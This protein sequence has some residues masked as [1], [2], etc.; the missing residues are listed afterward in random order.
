LQDDLLVAGLDL[1]TGREVHVSDADR[2]YWHARGYSGR[3]T[4]VCA[5]CYTGIDDAPGTR[6]PLVVRGRIGGL[7]RLHFAH[8]PGQAPVGGHHPESVWHLSAKA[9][10]AAWAC[11]QPGVVDVAVERCTPDRARRSDVRVRFYDGRQVALEVQAAPLT[12]Q[13]WSARHADY[14]RQ[15]IIDVWL[16]RPGTRPHW[17]VIDRGQSLWE[18]DPSK[19]RAYL[20]LGAAHDRL[21]SWWTEQDLHLYAHH[22]SPCVGDTLLRCELALRT[23][24]LTADGLVTP[25]SVHR[26]I[27]NSR[28]GVRDAAEQAQSAKARHIRPQPA[29]RPAGRPAPQVAEGLTARQLFA[30]SYQERRR[31]LRPLL[32]SEL[33]CNTCGLRLDPILA[34]IGR[35]IGC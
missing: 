3:R 7:R 27:D 29:E 30:A 24:G 28:A 8:P 17:V 6:V 35:H 32:P 1:E 10:L 13:E 25:D 23:I 12:D 34:R 5:L 11:R 15:G 22:E 20:L 14:Q 26:E 18:L 4:L 21:P 2:D 16:W 33:A 9:V 31:R 19:E